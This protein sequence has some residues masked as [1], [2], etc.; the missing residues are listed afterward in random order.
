M[1]FTG[2]QISL[3]LLKNSLAKIFPASLQD[4]GPGVPAV[5][6][7]TFG[8]LKPPLGSRRWKI[9]ELL[10][11]L[12]SAHGVGVD[13]ALIEA[14]ALEICL[15][16]FTQY[17]FNNLLHHGV[18]SLIKACMEGTARMRTHLLKTCGLVTWLANAPPAIA[19][20]NNAKPVRAGYMGHITLLGNNLVSLSARNAEVGNVMPVYAFLFLLSYL[21]V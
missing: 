11:V 18:T 14:G 10:S 21:I 4:P 2:L 16:L 1:P 3:A 17:P 8:E 6:K 19:A 15:Q 5:L 12:A 13:K 9:V 20:T 7:T